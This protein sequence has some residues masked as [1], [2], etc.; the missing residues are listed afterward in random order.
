VS[1]CAAK[2][3]VNVIVNEM[4]NVKVVSRVVVNECMNELEVAKSKGERKGRWTVPI[5]KAW[6]QIDSGGARWALKEKDASRESAL[7]EVK[8]ERS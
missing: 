1:E 8:D 4:V 2:V 5:F 3:N 7:G 6:G